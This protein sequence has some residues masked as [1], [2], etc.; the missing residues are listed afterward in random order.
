MNDETEV[1]LRDIEKEIKE[2]TKEI[3]E[4]LRVASL[5]AGAD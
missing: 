2:A 4:L 1:S 5:L 3:L